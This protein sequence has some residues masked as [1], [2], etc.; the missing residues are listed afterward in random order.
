VKRVPT[1][2]VWVLGAWLLLAWCVV[3][4]N[5]DRVAR[6]AEVD[7]AAQRA[8]PV[9]ATVVGVGGEIHFGGSRWQPARTADS[10]VVNYDDPM[11]GPHRLRVA[12]FRAADFPQ[13]S[14][15][16]F[17]VDPRDTNRRFFDDGRVLPEESAKLAD[18]DGLVVLLLFA[19][20]L[21]LLLWAA[22]FVGWAATLLP[23]GER[24]TAVPYDGWVGGRWL[25]GGRRTLVVTMPAGPC[26]QRVMWEPWLADLVAEGGAAAGIEVV[27]REVAGCWLA[28]RV[29]GGGR[30]LPAGLGS[31][32]P[33]PADARP[34]WPG[35]RLRHRWVTALVYVLPGAALG[36]LG[37]RWYTVGLGA[38]VVALLWLYC[39]GRPNALLSALTS[40]PL[41]WPYGLEAG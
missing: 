40:R 7:G 35:R 25:F 31:G 4:V 23:G 5:R 2:A 17:R 19:C 16:T 9:T 27:A 26:R 8:V 38:G 15:L 18:T 39:G 24:V 36:A 14:T 11:L 6:E 1:S 22:Q 20:L 30:L 37:Q 29:V 33:A 34:R 41:T 13:G 28:L 3:L 12:V 32:T 21:L 10:I